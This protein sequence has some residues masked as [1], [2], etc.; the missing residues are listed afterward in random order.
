MPR[1][2]RG[3]L[4]EAIDIFTCV[5]E[6]VW[7]RKF[8]E[9]PAQIHQGHNLPYSSTRVA[10]VFWLWES[11]GRARFLGPRPITTTA[12][13]TCR[14]R[15]YDTKKRRWFHSSQGACAWD[16]GRIALFSH[17]T[18][19][20][21]KCDASRGRGSTMLKAQKR[22]VAEH[23]SM[24]KHQTLRYCSTKGRPKAQKAGKYVPMM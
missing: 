5:C 12:C 3:K 16:R 4:M 17:G 2:Q 9:A 1:T 24:P 21:A 18:C 13:R 20:E 22:A 10:H 6:V 7:G 15:E 19:L 8:H 14:A 23:V 11:Y